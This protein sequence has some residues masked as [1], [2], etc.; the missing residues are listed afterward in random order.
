M[1]SRRSG[2]IAVM[3][4]AGGGGDLAVIHHVGMRHA[5]RRRR[6]M[7]EGQH[8]WRRHEAECREDRKHD[9]QP[10]AEPGS[11]GGQHGFSIDP[12]MPTVG[13]E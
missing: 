13:P 4:H 12:P 6:A 7:A 2:M 10:E 8:G 1:V 5:I 3:L 11:E 9:C